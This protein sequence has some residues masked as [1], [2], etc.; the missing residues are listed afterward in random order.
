MAK[1]EKTADEEKPKRR[2]R[3]KADEGADAAPKAEAKKP[4]TKASKAKAPAEANEPAA[5]PATTTP[6]AGTLDASLLP[7]Q[8]GKLGVFGGPR[9][10]GIKPDDKLALPTGK[11]FSFERVRSLNP[12]SFYCA[13]RWDYHLLGK[14]NEEG[15]RWW[16]NKK[17]LVTNPAS[18]VAV[19]VRAVDY[20][21]PESTGLS[22]A[23]SP[24]AAE[25]LGANVGDEVEINFA[26]PRLPTGVVQQG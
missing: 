24:G 14:S 18:G 23:V 5:A 25:A 8:R 13:M 4:A 17:L 19:V 26:D 6:A 3:K 15:K 21:P 12:K 2:T 10:R 11:H 22:I 9:D 1:A 20:G 16:A 7:A